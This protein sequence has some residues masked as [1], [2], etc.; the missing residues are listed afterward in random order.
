M[1]GNTKYRAGAS[2]DDIAAFQASLVQEHGLACEIVILGG[3]A[4]QSKLYQ[5]EARLYEL[6]GDLSGARV[7]LQVNRGGMLKRG[8]AQASQV[9]LVLMQA[10]HNYQNDPWNWTLSDRKREASARE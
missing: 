8:D 2:W 5:V 1:S 6:R 10:Y 7:Y 9:M 4:H 3:H